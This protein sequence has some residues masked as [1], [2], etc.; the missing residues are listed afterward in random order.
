[1]RTIWQAGWE[2]KNQP[3]GTDILWFEVIGNAF[4]YHMV[5]HLVFTQ[6]QFGQG[7]LEM[8][9]FLN[10]LDNGIIRTSG[11]APANGLILTKVIYGD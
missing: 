6:V 9:E 8:G 7:R 5:R 3:I 11:L 1:V 2:Q 4:L 10:A